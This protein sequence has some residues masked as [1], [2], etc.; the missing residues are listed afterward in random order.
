MKIVCGSCSAKYTVSDE[1]VQGKSV[2]VK[3][4]KCGAVIVVSPNGDV[5]TEGG[6]AAPTPSVTYTVSVSD[7]DQ[8]SMTVPEIV[9]AYNEGVVDAETFVW[10]EGMDDWLALKDVA[11][12]VDALYASNEAP[13]VAAATLDGTLAMSEGGALNY[14][15]AVA[16]QRAAAAPAPADALNATMAMDTGAAGGLFGASAPSAGLFGSSGS[17][18][19]GSSGSSGGSGSVGSLFGGFG[20]GGFGGGSSGFGGGSKSD[21]NSAI[22]SLNTLTSKSGGGP[23]KPKSSAS[24]DSG[25]IDLKALAAGV[26]ASG[27]VAP[28]APFSDGG[29]FPLAAPPPPAA[30]SPV[31]V[32][33]PQVVE[34]AKPANKGLLAALGGLVV[35]LLCA[36]VFLAMRGT[37]AAPTPTADA[38]KTADPTAEL[39]A[40]ATA[41]AAATADAPQAGATAT[42]AASASDAEPK[43]AAAKAETPPPP[44]GGAKSPAGAGAA[45][46]AAATPPPPPPAAA[47]T[48]AGG[49]APDDLMCLMRAGAKKKK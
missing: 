3:C 48:S 35:L 26:G 36:V 38:P 25:L 45:A 34:V 8:R 10:S 17:F 28:A 21:E 29:L 24:E 1:K 49:C 7:S 4:R 41:T 13:A 43:V 37:P 22:F 30:P 42:A 40:T 2:K 47:K 11:A 5:R 12:I 6:A 15:A 27:D 31:V 19:S 23:A 32:A 20:G 9:I 14:E 39:A 46:A 18:G 44:A 16:A 33:A